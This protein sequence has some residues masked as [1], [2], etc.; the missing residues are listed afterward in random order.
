MCRRPVR[1]VEYFHVLPA[2]GEMAK[3]QGLRAEPGVVDKTTRRGWLLLVL[4]KPDPALHFPATST[5]TQVFGRTAKVAHQ[6]A[7]LENAQEQV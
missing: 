2:N 7:P 4:S 5:A 3:P 1:P 6:D